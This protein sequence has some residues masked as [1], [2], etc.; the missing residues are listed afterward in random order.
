MVIAAPVRKGLVAKRLAK[1]NPELSPAEIGRIVGT[2]ASYIKV[3]L[4]KPTLGRDR[5]KSRAL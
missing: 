1:E 5:V 2:G 3:A 4:A